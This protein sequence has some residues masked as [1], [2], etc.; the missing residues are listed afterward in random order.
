[1]VSFRYS[2]WD[3]TQSPFDFD[4][5]DILEALSEDIMDH[6]DVGRA[7]RNL[8]RGG[9]SGDDGQRITGMR[10]LKERLK[11]LQQQ[12]LERYNLESAMDDIAERF[13]TSSTPS[14]VASSA[15]CRRPTTS[16]KRRERPRIC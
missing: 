5:D 16:F 11:R 15:G 10:E 4:E 12:Q 8:M 3:G 7:M 1:M 6:G 9:M 14:G 2:R 13:R